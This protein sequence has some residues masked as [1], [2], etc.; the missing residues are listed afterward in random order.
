[1][2]IIL[3][4]VLYNLL[5]GLRVARSIVCK[6]WEVALKVVP[7]YIRTAKSNKN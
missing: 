6:A 4:I 5:T 7:L 3:D 2:G 1:M